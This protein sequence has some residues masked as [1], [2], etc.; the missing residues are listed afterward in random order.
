M[1]TNVLII[2]GG[3]IGVSTAYVLSKAGVDV[4]LLE[5]G[6][7]S[8]GAS[9]GNAGYIVPC[10]SNPIPAPGVLTQGL[11]WLLDPES[12]FYIKPSLSPDL[13]R[14][15]WQFQKFCNHDDYW[16]AIPIIRDM[17]RTSQSLF[18][19]WIAAEGIEA[20]FRENGGITLYKDAH[21]FDA[22]C[23]EAEELRKYDIHFDILDTKALQALEP[24]I[25]DEVVGG[26]GCDTDAYIAPAL[27]TRSLALKA[28]EH[29]AHILSHTSVL[30]FEINGAEIKRVRTAQGEIEAEQVLLA[31]G[32]WTTPLAKELDVDILMQPAKG[33]SVTLKNPSALPGRYLFLGKSKVA[34]TPMGA[35][36][37]YAGTLE[38]NGYNLSINSRRLGALRKAG[39]TY[40][41]KIDGEEEPESWAGLRPVSPDG[42]PYIGRSARV[43][44]LVIATGH[45]MLGVAMGPFTGLLAAEVLQGQNPSFDLTPFNVERFA[46]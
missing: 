5:M 14:W 35:H 33:Y 18:R 41:H 29:G 46:R 8:S 36:L 43:S 31:A 21:A 11:K 4:T 26:V 15:L 45:A 22:M 9:Y 7:V 28:Q 17:Q 24:L 30:G 38:L 42:L 25:R 23:K 12:P 6:E 39:D 3:V 16:R 40:L 19:E 1:K 44:N 37:R 27:F 13:L 20:H 32:A 10:H 34:V 2:G